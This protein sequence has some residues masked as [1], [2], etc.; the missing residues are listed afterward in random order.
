MGD[1]VRWET[2]SALAGPDAR[3]RFGERQI[4]SQYL[5]FYQYAIDITARRMAKRAP[6]ETPAQPA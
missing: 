1:V 6:V 4:V 3:E 2:A 5:E